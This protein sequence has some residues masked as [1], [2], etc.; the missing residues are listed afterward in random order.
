MSTTYFADVM[1]DGRVRACLMTDGPEVGPP[2]VQNTEGFPVIV[3]SPID[4]RGPTET[5]VLHWSAEDGLFWVET[6]SVE[7]L[8]A[9]R[10]EQINTW[11]LEA[12]NSYFEYRRARIAYSES[13]TGIPHEFRW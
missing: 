7:F 3:P 5:S 8:R 11:W 9:A 6:A 12:N 2:I 1:P 13:D 10:R 4:W